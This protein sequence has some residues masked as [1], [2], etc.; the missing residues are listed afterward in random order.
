M[1]PYITA[2]LQKGGLSVGMVVN[3]AIE[4]GDYKVDFQP[5]DANVFQ[6]AQEIQALEQRIPNF[7]KMS[8]ALQRRLGQQL[9]SGQGFQLASHVPHYV[10]APFGQQRST[11][12]HSGTDIAGAGVGAQSSV[13]PITITNLENS[14]GGGKGWQG[15]FQT[16]TNKKVEIRSLHHSELYGK[17]GET[18]QPGTAIAKIGS[19]GRSSGPHQHLEFYIDGKLVDGETTLPGDDKRLIDYIV[20]HKS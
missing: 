5:L 6:D 15:I 13:V 3:E 1:T 12:T 16:H 19:T 8:P 7:S 20:G 11:G 14:A 10:T 9:D 4:H 17:I 2:R 18:I